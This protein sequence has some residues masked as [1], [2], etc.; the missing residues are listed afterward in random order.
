MSRPPRRLRCLSS[1][2]AVMAL[3]AGCQ[4]E[5]PA[6]PVGRGTVPGISAAK[7]V[8]VWA[9]GDGTTEG[10]QAR[11]IAEMIAEAEPDR[12]LYLGDVYDDY[13]DRFDATFGAAGL[14]DI[15][16]PTPGNHEWPSQ[17]EGYLEYWHGVR[18]EPLGPYYWTRLG[19]WQVLSINTEE[20]TGP[21]SP[22]LRWL[23]R[24]LKG[25][26]T[27]RLAFMHRP[28]WSAGRHGDQEDV[29]PVWDALRGHAVLVLSGHDHDMQ[30]L[31]ELDGITQL[32]AGAGG[33]GLYEVDESDPRVRFSNDTDFGALRL[34]LEPGKAT[35]SFVSVDGEEL[36]TGQV[37]CDQG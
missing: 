18:G 29:D 36:H 11:A 19:G 22:Q 8:D 16:L 10:P 23:E 37:P 5:A 3:L 7:P 15:T 27:C 24:S 21:G 17:R 25:D 30:Q 2:L 28:R 20:P 6:A 32:V 1:A 13:S 9:V 31:E 35:Y 33:R 34:R 14:V 4:T 26:G 12:V